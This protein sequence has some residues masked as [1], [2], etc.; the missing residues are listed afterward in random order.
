MV[1]SCGE[2]SRGSGEE[3]HVG[4]RGRPRKTWLEVVKNGMK[5][6]GQSVDALELHA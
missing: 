4:I 6:L 2:E 5:R 3:I 1:C